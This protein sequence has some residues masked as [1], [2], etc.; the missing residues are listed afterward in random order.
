MKKEKKNHYINV[1]LITIKKTD[2]KKNY[3]DVLELP[4]YNY[5]TFY[6]TD[7]QYF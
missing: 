2:S 6:K 3:F 7:Y 5:L 4:D 1:K